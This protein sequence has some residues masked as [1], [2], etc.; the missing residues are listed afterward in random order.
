MVTFFDNNINRPIFYSLSLFL[1]RCVADV[2]HTC[3][4]SLPER[5]NRF[6]IVRGHQLIHERL[7]YPRELLVALVA[8][9]GLAGLV[10]DLL[11]LG[12]CR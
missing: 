2:S 8:L 7:E 3:S 6:V 11:A 4:N 12:Y 10:V 1:Q 5:D 9:L